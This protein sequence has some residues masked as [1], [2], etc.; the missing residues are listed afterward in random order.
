MDD[1]R[2]IRI[3]GVAKIEKRVAEF[4][5]WELNKTPYAKFKVKI[6]EWQDNQFT[7]FTNIG[8]RYQI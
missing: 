4:Q 2:N 5:V 6:I 3:E 7:G 8:V 1:W